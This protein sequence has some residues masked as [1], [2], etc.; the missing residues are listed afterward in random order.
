[1]HACGDLY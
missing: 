1:M